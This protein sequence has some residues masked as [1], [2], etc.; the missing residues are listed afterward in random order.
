MNKREVVF[1]AYTAREAIIKPGKTGGLVIL[2]SSLISLVS[3]LP[4]PPPLSTCVLKEVRPFGY[5]L[6]VLVKV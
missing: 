1:F 4:S 3:A 2:G 6:A 5:L